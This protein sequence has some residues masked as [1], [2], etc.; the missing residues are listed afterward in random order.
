MCE[1]DRG[2]V[3]AAA[4][5]SD[6]GHGSLAGVR[7]GLYQLAVSNGQFHSSRRK[8]RQN[9]AGL[10]APRSCMHCLATHTHTHTLKE[11]KNCT[12]RPVVLE[13]EGLCV[14]RSGWDDCDTTPS[15]CINY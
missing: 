7:A 3:A 8:S 14:H 4:C 1:E 2:K 11:C 6:P 13:R 12:D 15:L 5:P 10:P 9:L